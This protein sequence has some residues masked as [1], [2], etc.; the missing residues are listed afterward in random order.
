MSWLSDVG[1]SIGDFA[2]GAADVVTDVG[3][4]IAKTV[5]APG[6]IITGNTW[7]PGFNSGLGRDVLSPIV[8]IGHDVATVMA[9]NIVAPINS[10]TGHKFNTQYDTGI[11][12]LQGDI[13]EFG[14]NSIHDLGKT[15]GD[16]VT[17]GYASKIVNSIRPSDSQESFLNYQEG[18]ASI[19]KDSPLA[20]IEQTVLGVGEKVGVA[21][22]SMY[23]L[24][25]PKTSAP[26]TPEST[27]PATAA[28]LMAATPPPTTQNPAMFIVVVAAAVIA[29]A[30]G[31]FMF[32]T[33]SK[34]Q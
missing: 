31:A 15:I 34:A 32:L 25:P 6:E 19:K 4:A 24:G 27:L 13:G 16:T 11:G 20:G 14:V 22:G 29:L 28:D 23:G 7:N 21:F 18:A 12:K 1:D 30:V 2:K 17:G 9:Y 33:K 26:A 10:V 8:G 3:K 5:V